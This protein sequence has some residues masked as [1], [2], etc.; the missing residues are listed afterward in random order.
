MFAFHT[1][2]FIHT[3]IHIH[4]IID[5]FTAF[6]HLAIDSDSVFIVRIDFSFFWYVVS[7]NTT[8]ITFWL[9]LKAGIFRSLH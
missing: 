2:H 5:T 8:I 4:T 3:H 9:F 1:S 6:V 7:F